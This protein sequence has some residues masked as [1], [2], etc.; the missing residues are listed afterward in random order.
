M[1][2][3][4]SPRK[5]HI[6]PSKMKN[7]GSTP[8]ELASVIS[9]DCKAKSADGK[10]NGDS[11]GMKKNAVKTNER[12]MASV[13]VKPSSEAKE[14][15]RAVNK[16]TKKSDSKVTK[17]PDKVENNIPGFTSGGSAAFP[18]AGGKKMKKI[19]IKKIVRKICTKDNQTS[20]PIVSE[21][22]DD[23]DANANASE[24]EE[25]EITSS[26]FEKDAISAHNLVST[27]DTAGVGNSVEVQKEQSNDLVNLSK[28]NASPTIASTCVFDTS[29]SMREH[30]GKEDK[31]FKNSV[32]G[33]ASPAIESTKTFNTTSEHPGREEYG[34]LIN[35]SGIN[36]EK[37][38]GGAILAVSGALNEVE[39]IEDKF[40]EVMSGNNA[41]YVHG[42]KDDAAEVSGSGNA[43]REEGDFLVRDSIGRPMTVE[44]SMAMSKDD[45]EKEGTILMDASEVCVASLENSE[46]PSKI[47]EA[48]DTHVAHKEV[49]ML[50]NPRDNTLEISVN[51][52]KEKECRIPIDPSETVA[53][54]THKLTASNTPEVSVIESVQKESQMAIYPSSSEKIQCPEAPN[55]AKV[56]SKFAQSE[57]GK[58]SMDLSGKYVGTSDNSVCAPEFLLHDLRPS[59]DIE[60]TTLSSLNDDP[61]KDSSGAFNLDNGVGR[62]TV[63]QVAELTHLHRTHQSP[64][65][66][67]SLSHFHV[68]PSVSGNSEHSVPTALTLG[69]NIYFSRTESEQQHEENCK[70]V[71]VNQGF[72]VMTKTEFGSVSNRK[73]ETGN[74]LIN[75]GVQNWL[76]LPLT[77]SYVNNDV[78]GSTDRLDLYQVMD[79]GASVSHDHDIMPDMEQRGSIDALSGQDD[80]LSLCGNNTPQSD[81]LATK[82]RNKDID[83]ESEAILSGYGSSV[84]VLGQYSFHTVDKPIDKPVLLS[85]HSLDV[86][87]GELASSQVFVNPDHTYHNNTEDHV[88]VPS[89]KPDPLSSWIE[90]IVSEAK[91]EYQSCKST[92]HSISS[93][94][95]KLKLSAS[96]E[97]SRKAVSDSVVN[98]VV[99]SP[100]R[101][102][103]A[104]S[105]V[106][107]IPAKQVAL[108]SSSRDPP[109]LNQNARHRTWRRDN[110]SSLH[111]SQPSGLPPKLPIKKNG[112]SQNSYI[113]KGNALIRNPAT[114]NH[115]HSSN[116]DVQNKLIKP[117]MRRSLNFVRKV[118]SSD[119]VAHSNLSVERPKTPP[120]PLHTKSISCAVNLLEPLSQTLQNQQLLEAEKEDSNGQVNSGVDNPLHRSEPPDAGKAVCV[121]PKLNQLVASQ[122][123][124]PGD[125]SNS[126][127]DKVM[128][129]SATPDLY[130]K[131]RKNQI[132][133]GS[134]TSDV[135]NANDMTQAENIK[136]GESK[137]L[138]FASSNTVAKGPHRGNILCKTLAPGNI[139]LLLFS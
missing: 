58:R 87:G 101:V 15:E 128:Q 55:T 132:V 91:K 1:Y 133:L 38:E 131:K 75:A 29:V 24:K 57:A 110:V 39:N 8:K 92:Q 114:G 22:K 81:L 138:M 52:N 83:G 135:L 85:S 130:F 68:S 115:P 121:R 113:R 62:N 10:D 34:G 117:V 119:A 97:D 20:S 118:D 129:P 120:L 86:P 56:I 65:N 79:K 107:K 80:S 77:V 94:P 50:K 103:I 36:A 123:H 84:N 127:K 3:P 27:S 17:K 16:A 96:K 12:V 124:H 45:N 106:L 21:K 89:T 139:N 136:S 63:S 11:A 67:F 116:L 42:G 122:G 82:E 59:R 76:T 74:D 93:S 105:T 4:P 28:C 78:T 108:P 47:A 66:N 104:S 48:A 95:D 61:T 64:D 33:N 99:K 125:S 54:F 25:G 112:Q 37:E 51:E 44:F 5:V 43:R 31:S 30:P 111:V 35:S 53:S 9:L 98:A 90:A 88:A 23:I 60:S 100:P 18:G 6:S 109:R 32:G 46:A 71:E 7:S 13:L 26:S 49:G 41:S 19:V 2:A 126:S 102:N 70:L 69:N 134:S 73:G 137:S 14:K 72:D 40:N